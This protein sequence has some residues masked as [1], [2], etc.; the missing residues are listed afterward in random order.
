M[1][2]R[3]FD[4]G[5]YVY[6]ENSCIKGWHKC[7][8]NEFFANMPAYTGELDDKMLKWIG[9]KI[10]KELMLKVF[11]LISHF[12]NTEVMICLYYNTIEKK[13]MAH[14][15]KQKGSPAHVAYS[16]EDWET[17][18]GWTFLGTIHTHPNMAAF[19]S[20]TDTTD[21][22]LKDGLHIVL[23]LTSGKVTSYQCSLFYNKK[24]Y[25][26][27]DAVDMPDNDDVIPEADAEWVSRVEVEYIPEPRAKSG[28]LYDF[29]QYGVVEPVETWPILNDAEDDDEFILSTL[30][31]LAKYPEDVAYSLV[32]EILQTLGENMLSEAVGEAR[33]ENINASL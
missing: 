10:D 33:L 24:R 9:G 22:T 13:W 23:G 26:Q 16:D 29:Q 2:T 8:S 12:P 17:P 27:K 14:I 28:S 20:G 1:K 30:S 32:Q 4:N 5:G 19:W 15:P 21:Q 18:Q 3:M 6:I 7:E 11:A 25:D 31:C